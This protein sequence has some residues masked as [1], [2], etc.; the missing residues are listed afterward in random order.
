MLVGLSYLMV[1]LTNTFGLNRTFQILSGV[2][3]VICLLA[4]QALIPTDFPN[5]RRTDEAE[6]K[7][8]MVYLKLLKNKK[9]C[10]FMLANFTFSFSY[11]IAYL[12]QVLRSHISDLVIITV[13]V[14]KREKRDLLLYA[15]KI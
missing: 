10:V 2:F 15:P 5:E 1:G 11:P 6:R 9:L 3:F 4:V 13:C 8:I 7:S 12:H 14:L